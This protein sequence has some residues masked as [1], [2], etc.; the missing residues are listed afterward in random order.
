M[1]RLTQFAQVLLTLCCGVL[2][3]AALNLFIDSVVLIAG[4][5]ARGWFNM[6][7]LHHN[8]FISWRYDHVTQA[9]LALLPYELLRE[10]PLVSLSVLLLG[11]VILGYSTRKAEGIGTLSGLVLS[12]APG[13]L[14]VL[15][16]GGDPFVIGSLCWI[17]LI[18]AL[19][20]SLLKNPNSSVLWV[21]LGLMSL[22]NSFA[23]NQ[24]SLVAGAVAL[25]FAYTIFRSLVSEPLP[26]R[27]THFWLGVIV[28][29]PAV[30]TTV[31]IPMPPLPRYPRDSHLV[32]DPI[33]DLP[34]HALIGPVYQFKSMSTYA[35]SQTYTFA[36]Y[37]LIILSG[38][39]W[40]FAYIR[41]HPLLR[42]LV[43][44]SIVLAACALLDTTLP[45]EWATIA[46]IASA[47]RLLPWAT[48]YSLTSIVLGLSALGLGYVV[49]VGRYKRV[50]VLTAIAAVILFKHDSQ[51]LFHPYLR[52]NSLTSDPALMPILVT[53]SAGM[54][55]AFHPEHPQTRA[56]L[57][58]MSSLSK[59]PTVDVNTL[60][61]TVHIAPE[62]SNEEM[63][64][65]A[66]NEKNF[67]W[68][69]RTGQQKGDEVLTIRFPSP[70]SVRGVELDPGDYAFDY[71]RGLKVV[72]GD[73]TND[74]EKKVLFLSP[75]WQGTIKFTP[76][77]APYLSPRNQVKALFSEATT[78][79][80]LFIHQIGRTSNNDWSVA[81]VA[82]VP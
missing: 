36:S 72:G 50:V 48:N 61:A 78:I 53:P 5:P 27:D 33:F 19:S 45:A 46:P 24:L 22:E 64:L 23:A 55:R 9:L 14:T 47:S 17:P 32:P 37:T 52:R 8:A 42:R 51:E 80:C 75:V 16:V 79:T 21:A 60:G 4:E 1:K 30:I 35:V 26:T 31:T 69:T 63:A 74:T 56:W 67:R 20:F 28:L 57:R 65:T 2:L 10:K 70:T 62:P 71:P 39:M 7:N 58:E 6:I 15:T 73:C 54:I 18:A 81:R 66:R 49:A 29:L 77:G 68:S 76:S 11:S 82:I 12:L 59:H 43:K 34:T 3:V 25:I 44:A 38:L 40:C 41:F 13:T